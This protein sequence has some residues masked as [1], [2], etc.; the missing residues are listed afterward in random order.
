MNQVCE[1]I[2]VD[3]GETVT[4]HFR[5]KQ[6]GELDAQAAMLYARLHTPLDRKYRVEIEAKENAEVSHGGENAS[7]MQTRPTNHP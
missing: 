5:V 4:W 7:P 1:I 6:N 3:D 2:R